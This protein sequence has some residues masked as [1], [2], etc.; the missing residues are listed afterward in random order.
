MFLSAASTSY[1]WYENVCFLNAVQCLTSCFFALDLLDFEG[2]EPPSSG[3]NTNINNNDNLMV[4]PAAITTTASN[5]VWG[6]NDRLFAFINDIAHD[7]D[8]LHAHSFDSDDYHD[9]RNTNLAFEEDDDS[10]LFDER[11]NI[12][13]EFM[14][15]TMDTTASRQNR[16]DELIDTFHDKDMKLTTTSGFVD[17][18]ALEQ[19]REEY[20]NLFMHADGVYSSPLTRALETAV[21]AL[22]DHPALLSNGLTLYSVVREIKRIGGLDTVGVECGD[23]IEHRLRAEMASILGYPRAEEL[24]KIPIIINDCNQPWWTPIAGHDSEK[25]QQERVREFLTFI[26]YC[27]SQVPVVVGHSLFFKAFY[28]KRVSNDL[29]KNRRALSEN[30]KKFRLSNAALLAVTVT[31]HHYQ[32]GGGQ[33]EAIM[34]DADLIFGGSFHGLR[35]DPDSAE[36]AS[37]PRKPP[38]RRASTGDTFLMGVL[39][40]DLKKELDNKKQAVT[41]GLKKFGNAMKDFWET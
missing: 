12:I 1:E 7:D 6:K 16:K 37:K 27:D 14:H 8:N 35:P 9:R 23:G 20:I 41:N 33:S 13:G 29:L 3:S 21:V 17:Q 38:T 31:F 40:S 4:A 34:I 24:T 10:Y 15:E 18:S 30:L 25:E 36:E 2:L 11:P 26:H 39:G 28:S 19:R 5:D 22:E 32:G